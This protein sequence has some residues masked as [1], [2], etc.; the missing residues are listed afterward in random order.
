MCRRVACL[1]SGIWTVCAALCTTTEGYLLFV[2]PEAERE[3]EPISNGNDQLD[4]KSD[5]GKNP[6]GAKPAIRYVEARRIGTCSFADRIA[7]LSIQHYRTHIPETV[8]TH[9]LPQTCIAT[10][11]AAFHVTKV[12]STSSPSTQQQQQQ[13]LEPEHIGIPPVVSLQVLAMGVGT[14]F[15]SEAMLTLERQIQSSNNN[16]NSNENM[17]RKSDTISASTGMTTAQYGTRIRDCHAEVLCRRAFRKYL[18]DCIEQFEIGELSPSDAASIDSISADNIQKSHHSSIL[19]RCMVVD[20]DPV[21]ASTPDQ[22]RQVRYRVRPDVSLHMYCS[23]TPCGNSTIKK[24]A[25]LQKEVYCTTLSNDTWPSNHHNHLENRTPVVGHSIPLGQ[26]A[27]LVKKDPS[28]TG[29][30]AATNVARGPKERTWPIYQTTAWCPPGTTT[31]WSNQGSL[32]TCSDK[33][34][35]WNYLGYQGSL[36]S[37]YLQEP[38]YITTITVGRKFSS[39]TCRRAVCCRL[40]AHMNVSTK[41]KSKKRVKMDQ[42]CD[43][44]IDSVCF[45]ATNCHEQPPTYQLH[46]PTVMGTGVYMDET[47]FIDLSAL[48]T[49][50][51]TTEDDCQKNDGDGVSQGTK[52][53][54][55][56]TTISKS[57][58]E[59][60]FHSPMSFVTWLQLPLSSSNCK[61]QDAEYKTEC[62][63]GSSG[64]LISDVYGDMLQSQVCTFALIKQFLRLQSMTSGRCKTSEEQIH[65]TT[66]TQTLH[67]YR[68]LK[69]LV[70]RSYEHVKDTLL[71]KHPVLRDWKQHANVGIDGKS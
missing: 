10:I 30:T 40:D 47:G 61:I 50:K 67:E 21:L 44:T 11:V 6:P 43:D 25:S 14:K 24:F 26:F 4:R 65:T 62:I 68:K 3:M 2:R 54:T 1:D 9:I 35:R 20:D 12:A 37:A 52:S 29:M 17:N 51:S 58:G 60:R 28:S 18:F 45:A 31:V 66:T 36:L 7:T 32:H 19:E 46:H 5:S 64:Y 8:R 69:Q 53:T 70:A 71:T 59:I 56:A 55:S 41:N 23:S 39:V 22:D 27:L 57:S 33:I 42:E 13:Q 34:A 48:S 16:D 38:I 63:D 49:T 15:L